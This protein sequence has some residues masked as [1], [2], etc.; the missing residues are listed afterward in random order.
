MNTKASSQ[1]TWLETIT[2]WPACPVRGQL[3][4]WLDFRTRHTSHLRRTGTVRAEHL[5]LLH[6]WMSSVPRDI[7]RRWQMINCEGCVK[8]DSHI[9]CRSTAVTLPRPCHSPMRIHTHTISFS[10]RSDAA[11]LPW[12]WGAAFWAACSWQGRGKAWNVWI[13]HDRTV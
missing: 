3:E 6:I 12:P 5:L 10:C 9:P 11:T 8:A 4:W 7:E 13:K 1:R 2:I